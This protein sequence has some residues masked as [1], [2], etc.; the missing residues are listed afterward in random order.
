MH[1]AG[2]HI[3]SFVG[4][5]LMGSLDIARHNIMHVT[6]VLG[7]PV[8]LYSGTQPLKYVVAVVFVVIYT[9]NKLLI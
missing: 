4:R 9:S 6:R 5:T 3:V 8:Q 1:K 2:L 7:F